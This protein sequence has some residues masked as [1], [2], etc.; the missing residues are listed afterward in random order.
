MEKK[1][2]VE[3]WLLTRIR[4]DDRSEYDRG[5][6]NALKWVLDNDNQ[7]SKTKTTEQ[8]CCNEKDNTQV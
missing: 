6:I 5:Y 2:R 1:E 8:A 7:R 3:A 4:K